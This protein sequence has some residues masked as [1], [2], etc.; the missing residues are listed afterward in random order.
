MSFKALSILTSKLFLNKYINDTVFKILRNKNWGIILSQDK[1]KL[2]DASEIKKMK[3]YKLSTAVWK[4][5]SFFIYICKNK[6]T[7]QKE[8]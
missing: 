8:V 1:Y 3:K 4:T 2:N 6:K 7:L 5:L